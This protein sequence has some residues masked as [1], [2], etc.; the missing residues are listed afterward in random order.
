MLERQRKN[1]EKLEQDSNSKIEAFIVKFIY[2]VLFIAYNI[3]ELW[4]V[5]LIG[6]Y[7]GRATELVFILVS[8][9]CTKSIFGKPLHFR[10]NLK[11]L[12]ISM[13]TFYV[14]VKITIGLGLS[15][16]MSS[17]V[18]ILCGSIT[19]YV[20]SYLY[21][22]EEEAKKENKRQTIIK[23]LNNDLSQEHIFEVCKGL[24]LKDYIADTVELFLTNTIQETA[25]ILE[26]DLSTI[27]RRIDTFIKSAS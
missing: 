23:I 22:E 18:G 5:Y 17:I 2:V 26:K 4:L 12:A 7:N 1:L 14:S 21:N 20:A 19:S 11:C 10:K 8:F 25:S 9:F 3:F 16:L 15:I 6:K 13:P 27:K 24:G